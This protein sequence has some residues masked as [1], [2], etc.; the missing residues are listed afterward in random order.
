MKS[1]HLIT[2]ELLVEASSEKEA[3]HKVSSIMNHDDVADYTITSGAEVGLL[4]KQ[5]KEALQKAPVKPVASSVQAA[6][7]KKPQQ[8][9]KSTPNKSN[10]TIPNNNQQITELIQH[11]RDNNMLVRL[12]VL[13]GKGVRL[14][15]PCRILNFDESTGLISVYHVDEKRVYTVHVN[16][17]DDFAIS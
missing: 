2:L 17:I 11:F 4:V 12:S 8:Q 7:V 5:A 15:I 3:M 9:V 16:E 10:P 6:T 1:H 13:K 14:S